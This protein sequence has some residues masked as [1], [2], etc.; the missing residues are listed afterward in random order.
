MFFY[1]LKILKYLCHKLKIIWSII[2]YI[3]YYILHWIS[4]KDNLTIHAHRALFDTIF[5]RQK[6]FHLILMLYP[7]IFLYTYEIL[8]V[9][10][11]G[12]F[13][14][15]FIEFW[16]SKF[17]NIKIF[18]LHSVKD[19]KAYLRWVV[20]QIEKV[21]GFFWHYPNCIELQFFIWIISKL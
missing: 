8:Q 13:N 15:L 5:N 4:H 2:S 18:F 3:F 17:R 19:G 6:L 12:I 9:C 7:L 16:I 1:P 20:I 14:I 10:K 11:I 21:Q